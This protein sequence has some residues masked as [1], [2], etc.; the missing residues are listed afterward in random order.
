MN[1]V[2]SSIFNIQHASF[3]VD[4]F[5]DVVDMVVHCSHSGEPFFCGGR[6]EFMVLIVAYGA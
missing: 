1:I 4:T 3:I 6:G 2:L 5:E